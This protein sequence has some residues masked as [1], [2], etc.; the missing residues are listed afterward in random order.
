MAD[1]ADDF[2]AAH[3]GH[4]EIQQDEVRVLTG[5]LLQRRCAVVR[6]GNHLNAR[7]RFQ[8]VAQHLASDRLVVH[9]QRLQSH[10]CTPKLRHL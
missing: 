4:L 6:F 9:D 7:D 5:D 1:L 10:A 8:F 3:L 2:K